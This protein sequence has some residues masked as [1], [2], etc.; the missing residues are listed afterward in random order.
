M[1]QGGSN[2]G[3]NV[4]NLPDTLLSVS[5]FFYCKLPPGE[6]CRNHAKVHCGH[7]SGQERGAHSC[8]EAILESL[9]QR[10]LQECNQLD[11][12]NLQTQT[13]SVPRGAHPLHKQSLTLR[14]DGRFVLDEHQGPYEAPSSMHVYKT[15]MNAQQTQVNLL[16]A[17][18]HRIACVMHFPTHVVGMHIPDGWAKKTS[19]QR[20]VS[21]GKARC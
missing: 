5:I 16:S 10:L 13:S 17:T 18:M 8:N 1:L 14:A 12:G 9:L 7:E 19:P 20:D 11:Q 2:E 4:R 6:D 3:Q 21:E 15:A